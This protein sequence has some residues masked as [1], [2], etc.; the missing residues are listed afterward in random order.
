VLMSD[1]QVS[2]AAR[3]LAAQ[4]WGARK[5]I[6]MARELELRARELPESERLRLLAALTR[7]VEV[8]PSLHE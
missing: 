2:G 1:T 5:P 6:R 4:R 7:R 3:E 8:G